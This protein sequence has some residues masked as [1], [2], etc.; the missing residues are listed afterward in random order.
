M[1][2]VR[3]D[4]QRLRRNGATVLWYCMVPSST[5]CSSSLRLLQDADTQ[6]LYG[7]LLPGTALYLGLQYKARVR[8]NQMHFPSAAVQS[9]QRVRDIALD[10]AVPEP[11]TFPLSLPSSCLLPSPPFLLPNSASHSP[12]PS[13]LACEIKCKTPH[14]SYNLYHS[15]SLIDLISPWVFSGADARSQPRMLP[16]LPTRVLGDVW[17]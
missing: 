11:P 16:Y 2:P 7:S 10:F 6:R 15:G 1:S 3:T 14:S 17:Y 5:T 8:S 4:V 12:T 9:V 13:P